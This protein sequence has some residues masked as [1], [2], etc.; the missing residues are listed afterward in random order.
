MIEERIL[1]EGE[2]EEIQTKY[3]RFLLQGCCCDPKVLEIV[4][5]KWRLK[6]G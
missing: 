6:P 4:C 5:V 2:L 3:E 1:K